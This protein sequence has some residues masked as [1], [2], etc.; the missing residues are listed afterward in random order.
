LAGGGFVGNFR[1]LFYDLVRDRFLDTEARGFPVAFTEDKS[2]LVTADGNTVSG[3]WM[4]SR[5]APTDS[6]P[7]WEARNPGI[8]G[9]PS[10]FP[11]ACED[12][13]LAAQGFYGGDVAVINYAEG[14]ML[15]SWR[16]HDSG[17]STLAFSPDGQLVV[18]GESTPTPDTCS[19]VVWSCSDLESIEPRHSLERHQQPVHAAIFTRDGRLLAT[20]DSDGRIILW[21][22]NTGGFRCE[23]YG[24]K[25]DIYTLAF[26]REGKTLASA[27]HDGTVK[28]WHVATGRELITFALESCGTSVAFSPDGNTL[29]ATSG[30]NPYEPDRLYIWRVSSLKEIEGAMEIAVQE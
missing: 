1:T 26:S 13:K 5:W 18:T 11:V 20:G 3:E 21:D 22:V 9:S 8:G 30:P 27:S 23:L 17:V 29:V 28:L 24:H 7:L 6:K 12:R 16:A 19:V 4:V 25:Q 10:C 14:R 15:K 2:E